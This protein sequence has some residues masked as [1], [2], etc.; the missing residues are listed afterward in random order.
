MTLK[1]NQKAPDFTLPDQD[2]AKHKLSDYQGQWVLVYFYPKDDTPG[3]TTEACTL[4]DNFPAFKKLKV[5]VFGISVD[6]EKS[7]KKFADKYQLPFTILADEDK[8]VVEKYGVWQEKSM[9]GKKYMGTVR[10]SYL[11]NPEGKIAKIY[12]KVKPAMHAEEVL[13]DI[14]ELSK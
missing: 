10:N 6:S 11:I 9:Y 13:A 3:C 1:I 5:K 12:E 8:K 4:R 7:H 2:G 14:K